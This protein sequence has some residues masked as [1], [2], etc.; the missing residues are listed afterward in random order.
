MVGK[1]WRAGDSPTTSAAL[2]LVTCS[3]HLAR[4]IAVLRL[5]PTAYRI[6]ARE[7]PRQPSSEQITC[8][9][10]SEPRL[11]SCWGLHTNCLRFLVPKYTHGR[12]HKI[13]PNSMPCSRCL[14]LAFGPKNTSQPSQGSGRGKKA[15]DVKG[16]RTEKKGEPLIRNKSCL[17]PLSEHQDPTLNQLNQSRSQLSRC[18]SAAQTSLEGAPTS[19]C[20]EEEGRAECGSRCTGT[21]R[22]SAMLSAHGSPVQMFPDPS[23]RPSLRGG[24]TAL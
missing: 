22:F 14:G 13:S 24:A 11:N 5:L 21:G 19:P 10:T 8:F 2:G 15:T 16:R 20:L 6:Q 1:A 7:Q 4:H 3:S 23:P 12:T 18:C 17:S 9:H